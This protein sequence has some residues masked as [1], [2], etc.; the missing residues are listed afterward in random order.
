MADKLKVFKNGTLTSADISGANNDEFILINNAATTQAVVKDIAVSTPISSF[1]SMKLYND[2]FNLGDFQDAT[3][4]E[5]IDSSAQLKVKFTPAPTMSEYTYYPN[6]YK[7]YTLKDSLNGAKFTV[8]DAVVKTKASNYVDT[9]PT[10]LAGVQKYIDNTLTTTNVVAASTSTQ[11]Q[12][13]SNP[14][15]YLES[16]NGSILWYLYYDGNSTTYLYYT[17]ATNGVGTSW[18]TMQTTSYRNY[19]PDMANNRILYVDS[20]GR[21][22]SYDIDTTAG[23]SL[24][25]ISTHSGAPSTYSGGICYC[26]GLYFYHQVGSFFGTQTYVFDPVTNI[27]SDI[28]GD[29]SFGASTYPVFSVAY[30]ASEDRYYAI[31]GYGQST[32]A[33]YTLDGAIG[34]VTNGTSTSQF[35]QQ[36]T[37][38]LVQ[39]LSSFSGIYQ[40]YNKDGFT[41]ID[42]SGYGHRLLC[43]NK[44]LVE[45]MTYN[46]EAFWSSNNSLIE[47]LDS[48]GAVS[49]NGTMS[50]LDINLT[51]KVAGVESTGV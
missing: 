14:H 20:S 23:S 19:Q 17:N 33:L 46:S 15:W 43:Q 3:G 13:M 37:T 47:A 32:F 7:Y 45:D 41:Y 22:L 36:S 50:D 21:I 18:N 5:I 51:C 44:A 27:V 1:T 6:G 31:C 49:A 42:N 25:D 48:T 4:S 29:V 35:I 34:M 9:L 11:I 16:S 30:N 8:T 26:N 12:S 24:Y 28:L 38:P 40:T 39:P 10:A 2:G